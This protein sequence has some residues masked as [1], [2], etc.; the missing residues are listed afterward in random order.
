MRQQD[1]SD[2]KAVRLIDL[3]FAD[4]ELK[5]PRRI[6]AAECRVESAAA[7]GMCQSDAIGPV[8]Q[9]QP[10]QIIEAAIKQRLI[11]T[12]SGKVTEEGG[13]IVRIK[14]GSVL[15]LTMQHSALVV[16][17]LCAQLAPAGLLT[18]WAAEEVH[19]AVLRGIDITGPEQGQVAMRKQ[20]FAGPAFEVHVEDPAGLQDET[21]AAFNVCGRSCRL[22]Q[23]AG[24]FIQLPQSHGS[25]A[26]FEEQIVVVERS[27][28]D[29]VFK[30][31]SG[32]A[33]N[34]QAAI[35]SSVLQTPDTVVAGSVSIVA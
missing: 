14:C 18:V 5:V 24:R 35:G 3:G 33:G 27:A 10:R 23:F 29:D 34:E 17:K 1:C 32:D 30:V 22:V 25:S 11:K 6:M 4:Q 19:R 15:I 21:C 13:A 31:Q 28:V 20:V 12:Q 7:G 9:D 26:R 16:V 8:E 2:G